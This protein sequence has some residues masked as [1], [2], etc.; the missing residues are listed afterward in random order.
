PAAKIDDV[1]KL[2][3]DSHRPLIIGGDGIH[4]NHGADAFTSMVETLE[5]P[6]STLRLARGTVDEKRNDTWI[7]PA[8]VPA[9]PVFSEALESADFIMLLGHHWEFDL[10]FGKAIRDE[11]TVVQI[12]QDAAMLGRNGRVDQEICATADQFLAQ[13]GNVTTPDLDRAWVRR[14]RSSWVAQRQ[15]Y[16]VADESNA[17]HPLEIVDALADACPPSTRFVTSHGNVDFWAD[18][19]LL[20]D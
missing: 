20:I 15:D 16:P 10:E 6:V 13:L 7:G 8:Y 14:L 11:A 1:R 4:H 12:H 18:P 9:N 2:I 3:E 19:H 17:P 5:S